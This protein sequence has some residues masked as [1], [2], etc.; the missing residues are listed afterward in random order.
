MRSGGGAGARSTGISLGEPAW[1]FV[2]RVSSPMSPKNFAASALRATWTRIASFSWGWLWGY[3]EF[4]LANYLYMATL[5]VGDGIIMSTI[6]LYLQQRYG[7]AYNLAAF[8]L[9]V[10]SLGGALI[11][12]RA[13]ISGSV[14]PF[15]GHWSDRSGSRWAAAGW[16]AVVTIAG[17]A[18]LAFDGGIG[19]ILLG[20]CLAAFGSG[21]L[22]A[23]LPAIVSDIHGQQGSF[24][25]SLLSTSGDVGSAIAPL[26]GYAML[27]IL[28][29]STLYLVSGSLLLI[30][31]A[32]CVLVVRRGAITKKLKHTP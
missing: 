21:M 20:V 4:L 30:G 9:P 22:L 6:T 12:L 7:D 3:R 13:I 28:S 32:A 25:M 16:G 14:A 1:K 8:V 29:L 10:T 19:V 17:C 27:K 15:T 26:A 5:F 18:L 31:A 11:A 24:A 2:S 23:V